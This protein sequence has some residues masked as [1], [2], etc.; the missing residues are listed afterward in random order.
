MKNNQK[1]F[2]GIVVI[3]LIALALIG[4]GIY[5]YTKNGTPNDTALGQPSVTSHSTSTGIVSTKNKPTAPSGT[6]VAVTT[7]VFQGV[8]V[9]S[10]TGS[11]YGFMY[12]TDWDI[13]ELNPEVGLTIV[14]PNTKSDQVFNK[15][16]STSDKVTIS[17]VNKNQ[18]NLTGT[19]KIS[20]N[21]VV[22]YM[23]NLG[24]TDGATE[25]TLEYYKTFNS[26]E[27]VVIDSGISNK[28]TIELITASWKQD[29]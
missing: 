27:D 6:N 22:W 23:K 4:G 25:N 19:T 13:R 24:K 9:K 8:S 17:L 18:V 11:A 15:T 14:F 26:Y 2:I 1:G 21:G 3:V 16:I 12:P 5:V 10:F 20:F 7:S 29:Y 28:K